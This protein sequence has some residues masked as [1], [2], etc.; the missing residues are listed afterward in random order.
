MAQFLAG[1]GELTLKGS[2]I[3]T[4]ER[5]LKDNAKKALK[6]RGVEHSQ[7]LLH[8]GRLYVTCADEDAKKAEDA[9]AHLIGIANFAQ[10][11]TC[12]KDLN[13]IKKTATAECEK[14]LESLP[15]G[16]V[17]H[18]KAEAKRED[19]TFPF[20]SYQICCN[21]GEAI[22]KAFGE[23][24]KVDVNNPDL[25]IKIE[26]RDK[27]YIYSISNLSS[28]KNPLF[29]ATKGLPVGV[30][31]KALVLLSG[32]LD[33]PVAAFRLLK[34]GLSVDCVY[35]HSHPYTSLEAQQ[36]VEK[37]AQIVSTFAPQV[38]LNIVSLTEPQMKIK[39]FAPEDWSTLLLR[40]CM[41]KAA[42][43]V[44]LEAH[45][46]C[47]AT[48]ESLGQVASQTLEN[49]AVTAHYAALPLLRPLI[50]LDKEEII[51]TAR[52]IGTY[53]VS[54]LPYEDCCV[55]FTPRHPVLHASLQKAQ[56]LYD[57]LNEKANINSLLS[58]AVENRVVIHFENAKAT[59]TTNAKD[60]ADKVNETDQA[61]KTDEAGE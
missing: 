5:A 30:S 9:F 1:L 55:L 61:D 27:V 26:V 25:T 14:A 45:S 10:V 50:A 32:G 38:H 23:K 22:V 43:L 40:I 17:L 56:E 52:A 21:A 57:E 35:F 16:S 12:P 42:N 36:K 31:G 24:V 4:F 7:V 20:N 6:A 34:R 51:K 29:G 44:A 8:S 13:E 46:D 11:A 3:K 2:N 59:N 47:L 19:K 58:K 48:G 15:Q 33:S 18:F 39:E 60:A 37:L 54:I 53:E 41:M 49:L 28:K